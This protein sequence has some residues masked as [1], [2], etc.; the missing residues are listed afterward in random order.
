MKTALIVAV[1]FVL[2]DEEISRGA[3]KLLS[4]NFDHKSGIYRLEKA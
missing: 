3:T 1:K 2:S 4:T